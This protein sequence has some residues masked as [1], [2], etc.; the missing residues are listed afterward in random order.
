MSQGSFLMGLVSI[1]ICIC[2]YIY[3]YSFLKKGSQ[4]MYAGCQELKIT[5]RM[6]DR[7]V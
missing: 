5:A 3:I 1:S 7:R 4:R 6:G 2:I